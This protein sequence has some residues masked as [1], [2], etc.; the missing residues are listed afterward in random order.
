MDGV[1]VEK[2]VRHVDLRLG[3]SALRGALGTVS[4]FFLSA[5]KGTT[6]VKGRGG[7]P[8]RQKGDCQTQTI[9]HMYL[10]GSET[11]WDGGRPPC[12]PGSWLSGLAQL[13]IPDQHEAGCDGGE[14][15]LQ[16]QAAAKW[17]T[18]CTEHPCAD[19]SWWRL[20]SK[21]SH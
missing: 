19:R 6:S 21:P 15:L 18:I 4:A 9:V 11:G 10:P 16:H 1:D 2:A 12:G 3:F 5:P 8:L 20:Q 14:G 17:R 7:R 13:G